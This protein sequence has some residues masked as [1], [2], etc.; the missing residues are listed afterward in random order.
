MRLKPLFTFIAMT[1]VL[2]VAA[3]MP[4]TPV[5]PQTGPTPAEG[6]QVTP[7]AA[8][9]MMTPATEGQI[10]QQTLE[11]LNQQFNAATEQVESFSVISV[12]WPDSCLGLAA[13]DEM[14]AQ[15]ITPGWQI[16]TVIQGQ[17]YVVRTNQDGSL[18]R[19]DP[20]ASD[21]GV[22]DGVATPGVGDGVT[23]PDAATTPGVDDGVTTPAL[24]ETPEFA[25]TPDLDDG[26][27]TP[28]VGATPGVGD[29]TTPEAGQTPGAGQLPSDGVLMFLVREGTGA[30]TGT[31]TGQGTDPGTGTGTGMG[32]GQQQTEF[33][34]GT[35]GDV[36][37]GVRS[38][39]QV[40]EDD[41]SDTLRRVL[42]SMLDMDQQSAQGLNLANPVVEQELRLESVTLS[43]NGRASLR[44]FG[45]LSFTDN[46][47]APERLRQQ[48]EQT[49]LQ[50]DDVN[51]VR[52]YIN[53]ALLDD[54][55][56]SMGL[57]STGGGNQ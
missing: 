31:D 56:N 19:L 10:W 2:A 3:C 53:D 55:Y 20:Q 27:T 51:D 57:D 11:F 23:T 45:D 46:T 43:Q 29:V 8:P 7:P 22:G 6:E 35:C 26:V 42:R 36:L 5:I 32:V 50:F 1:M 24:G 33:P 25:A 18:I 54:L 40:D 30:G 17:R 21:E 48:I 52:I 15:V 41:P 49:A 14:C 38:N 34:F 9:G 13:G 44:F 4:A 12:N 16:T 28:E 39:V 47:C 37:V